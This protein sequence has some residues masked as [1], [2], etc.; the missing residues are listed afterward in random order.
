[1]TVPARQWRAILAEGRARLE[2]AGFGGLP[3]CI[4]KTQLSLSDDAKLRGAPTGWKLRV[5]DVKV[6][7][8]AGFVVVLAGKILLMPGMPAHGVVERIHLD[9]QGE[10]EGIG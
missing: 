9:A 10:I 6:S 4:A 2:R 3:I 7:A 8:G 1:M 5:R